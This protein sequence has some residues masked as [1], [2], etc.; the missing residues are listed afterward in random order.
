MLLLRGFR[1]RARTLFLLDFRKIQYH[2]RLA[3][4]YLWRGTI[5]LGFSHAHL[6]VV[7]QLILDLVHCTYLSFDLLHLFH[8]LFFSAGVWKTCNRFI[9][10][11][12][13]A[14]VC[15][16]GQKNIKHKK[17]RKI[18]RGNRQLSDFYAK[19]AQSDGRWAVQ[20]KRA[21]L[22]SI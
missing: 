20:S 22:D 9:F 13:F 4:L 19:L 11:F 21:V 7:Y 6:F 16:Q 8:L 15:F 2:S 17:A 10:G 18:Q 5:C 3:C 14:C 12:F 1:Q